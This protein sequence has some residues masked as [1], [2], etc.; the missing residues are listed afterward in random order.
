MLTSL[1]LSDDRRPANHSLF[2]HGLA[3][4]LGRLPA[5]LWAFAF[6]LVYAT[7]NTLHTAMLFGGATK[8][9]LAAH[10]LSHGFDLATFAG[11]MLKLSDGK[12]F[13]PNY[14]EP[15]LL[16]LAVYFLLVPGTL[17]CYQTDSPARLSTLL[18]TGLTH[19][20]RFVRIAVLSAVVMAAI[21]GPLGVLY[22]RYSS[23]VDDHIVGLPAALADLAA[24]L[25]IALLGAVLRLY[26]DLVEVYTVQLGLQTRPNGKPD[27]RVRRTL[28]PAWRALTRN[29]GRAYGVFVL[30]SALGLLALFLCGRAALLT[31]AQPRS[32]PLFLLTQAGL[33]LFLF[34]R[35]WQRGAE[36][37]LSLNHPLAEEKVKVE[38]DSLPARASFLPDPPAPRPEPPAPPAPEPSETIPQE[39][40]PA[41]T[42]PEAG[43]P[44]PLGETGSEGSVEGWSHQDPEVH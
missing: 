3:L 27:R 30:L 20:W 17:F 39:H 2:T 37:A 21:L 28:R 16:S 23:F 1:N 43:T 34:A 38:E 9:S 14:A 25:V 41:P 35:F 15:L 24:L 6:N 13:P 33:F 12:V 26:F 18:G 10:P 22:G 36:T 29:F 32:W 4:V 11:L 8:T 7:L 31:L 42:T 40:R 19:F 5:L 44:P